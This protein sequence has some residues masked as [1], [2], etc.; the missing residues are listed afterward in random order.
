MLFDHSNV[1][2]RARQENSH[3]YTQSIQHTWT[4][5]KPVT[6]QFAVGKTKTAQVVR[7]QFPLR[8]AAAKTTHRSQ[9]DTETRIVVNLETKRKI[10]HVTDLCENKIQVY[11]DVKTEM[12]RLRT[13]TSLNLCIPRLYE[14]SSSFFKLCFLNARSIHK[15]IDDLRNEH[16]F[17]SAELIICSETRF[18]PLDDDNMYIIQGYHLFQNDNQV[19]NTRPYAGTAIYSRHYFASGFPY[20]SNTNGIEITVV[21]VSTLPSVIT[22]TAIYRSPKISLA[23]LCRSLIQVLDNISSQY[24]LING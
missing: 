16:N 5:I 10:P 21:K 2:E 14:L 22:I 9:G 20:N 6:V 4:P 7:K 17:N 18:S 12:A 8:P 11:S 15:H 23:L 1:G 24:N 3:L 19:F 13:K